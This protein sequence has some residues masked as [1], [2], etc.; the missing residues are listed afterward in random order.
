MCEYCGQTNHRIPEVT[1]GSGTGS[2]GGDGA[3]KPT[4]T[5]DQI[6]QY[7]YQGYWEDTGRTQRSFD[8]QAG[9]QLTVNLSGLNTAG[10]NA[11]RKALESWT[12]LSGIEFV[13]T[14]GSAKITFD[15]NNSGAY[16][17]S[18]VSNGTI[19]SSHINVATNWASGNSDYYYQ[20]YIHEIGHALGLGHTGN[21]NGSASYGADADFANDSWQMSVM[22]Y[23]HQQQNTSIDASFAYLA[24]AQIGDIAAIHHLY[25]V[26]V[27]VETGNTT[28]GDGETTGRFGMDLNGGYAVAIVDSGG[29]DTIDLNTRSSA[30]MLNLNEET[31]S[32]LNGKIGN[33]SIA[34]GTVIENAITGSGNDTIIGNS[35][36]NRLESGG[37][38]DQITAAEGNDILIG[39]LARIL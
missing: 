13:E 18:T 15:D 14:T 26:P 25:G 22:S 17:S 8:V 28:Y 19:L 31:H 6:A 36:N 37:G 39:G 32:N 9:G 23:F 21:Y 27:N 35:A 16:A 20:T 7:L 1:D 30:Q 4:Y 10:K 38:N 12:A 29:I 5:V 11:A 24:T 34:G 2:G 3:G 33:F